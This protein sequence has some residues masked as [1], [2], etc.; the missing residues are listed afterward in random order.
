[1]SAMNE[2]ELEGELAQCQL[3]FKTQCKL[4]WRGIR[5]GFSYDGCTAVPDFDFGADCCGEHDYHYQAHDVSRSVADKKLRECIKKKGYVPLAWIY[6]FGVRVVG[7]AFWNKR[8]K[9]SSRATS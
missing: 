2:K 8:S 4:V 9:D 1:M 7:W 5:K 3:S 6:W